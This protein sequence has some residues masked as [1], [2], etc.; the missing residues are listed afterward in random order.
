MFTMNPE[1][2][3]RKEKQ[4]SGRCVVI[5]CLTASYKASGFQKFKD[6]NC[7]KVS[8]SELQEPV[9][10]FQSIV[11]LMVA[12][13]TIHSPEQV[14]NQIKLENSY[15]LCLGT[16]KQSCSWMNEHPAQQLCLKI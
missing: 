13:Q 9:E 12:N 16:N 8:I 5:K 14:M 3:A 7:R 6:Q 10:S 11:D 15:H 4:L 2:S 1:Q